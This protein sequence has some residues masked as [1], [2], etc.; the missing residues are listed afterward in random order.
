MIDL[1]QQYMIEMTTQDSWNENSFQQFDEKWNELK[2]IVSSISSEARS[3]E[4]TEEELIHCQ[5]LFVLYQ[6]I[7]DRTERQRNQLATQVQGVRQSKTIMNAYHGM[8]RK[9]QIAYY[10]DEKK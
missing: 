5:S 1:C 7:I 4:E 9:D 6:S 10:F 3:E 2:R 8:G